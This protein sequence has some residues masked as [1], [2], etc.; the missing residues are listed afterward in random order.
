MTNNPKHIEILAPCGSYDILQAA[1]KAGADACYIGGNRFGA[2]AYA[3]NLSDDSIIKAIDYAHLHEVKLYLTVNTLLKNNEISDLYDY[4]KPYYEAGLDAVIVQDFGVF[5]FIKENFYDLPIHCSTQM[6]VTSFYGA[7][8]MKNMGASR[9]VTAREMSLNSIREIKDK[10]D[11]EIESFVHGAMCYSYSGQCLMSSLAGGR[12][13]NRGRCAQPCRKCYKEGYTLSMKDMCSLE[14]LPHIIESGIDSLK[15][16]GR[17]KNEYYVA[18]AVDAYKEIANDCLLGCF[19]LEKALSYKEKLA[20]IYN[21]GGFCQGYYFMHNGPDMISEKRPNNQGT[22][23][24]KIKKVHSGKVDILLENEL[25]KQDVL[26]ISLNDGS[27]MDVTT[28]VSGNKGNIVTINAPKTKYIKSNQPIYR[29]KSN[30]IIMDIQDNI[31]NIKKKLPLTGTFT[32]CVGDMIYLTL[33]YKDFF[34]TVNTKDVV[35]KTREKKA[36]VELIKSKI[37]ML[38]NTDFYFQDLFLSVDEDA[39][40]P[41]GLVKSLR[42]EAIEKLSASI[43]QSFRRTIVNGKTNYIYPI[44][45]Q[46]TKKTLPLHIGVMSYSQLKGVTN[47]SCSSISMPIDVYLQALRDG[48][49]SLL[50]SKNTNIYIDLPHIINSD[51]D[52]SLYKGYEF[53]GIYIRN[54]DGYA[55][56]M[57]QYEEFSD[58]III[59][60]GSLYGYNNLARDFLSK[61]LNDFSF[62]LPK[63]LNIKELSTLNNYNNQLTI[64]EYQQVMLSAQCVIKNTTGC[65]A[66]NDKK[67][68]VDDMGNSFYFVAHCKGCYNVGYNGLPMCLFGKIDDII[69]RIKVDSYRINFTIEDKETVKQVLDMYTKCI[70]T[71]YNIN[72]D[73]IKITTG[74]YFRGVE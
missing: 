55:A 56:V 14:N 70:L 47:Y 26:E 9:I 12:S 23:M 10:I 53:D 45:T 43:C 1:V 61:N 63:E 64:Y 68:I 62:E 17:M 5:K 60:G 39:F 2:R 21:R 74:H 51:F 25:Y 38:G 18:S 29:T 13:G 59:L 19:N 24:G 35:E 20:A 52:L 72:S 46:Q 50:K 73:E 69:T 8:Y 30:K 49:I 7:S 48:I 67:I 44:E 15:I 22:Y 57:G 27:T 41:I 42:R 28:G 36:D 54:I 34:V 71:N 3:T 37:S 33:Q 6:N 66:S 58:K 40:I 65:T 31:I 32:A 4:I 11:I 16:E